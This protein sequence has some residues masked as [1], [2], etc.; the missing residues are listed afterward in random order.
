VEGLEEVDRVM[1]GAVE[2]V[3][4]CPVPVEAAQQATWGVKAGGLGLRTATGMAIPAHVASLVE[5]GP[6][7]EWLA[8]EAAAMGLAVACDVAEVV[9]REV[10]LMLAGVGEEMR[11][12]MSEAVEAAGEKARAA[13]E[14][15]LGSGGDGGGAASRKADEKANTGSGVGGGLQKDLL[16]LLDAMEVRGVMEGLRDSRVA[17]DRVRHRRLADLSGGGPTHAWLAAVNPAHGPVL[18]RRD[19]VTAVRLRLGVPVA[20]YPGLEPCGECGKRLAAEDVGDH[21]L[22]CA[23]GQRVRGHNRIRDHVAALARVADRATQ[24]EVAWA[25]AVEA[26]HHD[27]DRQRPADI[28]TDASPLGG[29]GSAAI[30]VGVTSPHTEDVLHGRSKDAVDDYYRK[31]RVQKGPVAERAGWTYHP[32][33]LSCYGRVHSEATRIV[34]RLALAAAQVYGVDDAGM[35][36]RSW[37]RTCGTLLAVRAAWMV[38]KC[39][40]DVAL[41]AVLG[42]VGDGV[43]AEVLPGAEDTEC[44]VD[45]LV[46]G[47]EVWGGE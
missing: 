41:P 9:R 46:G 34:H 38:G 6:L 11:G 23:R 39:R 26:R 24:V 27:A 10:A 25:T 12:Q 21:A 33:I 43:R 5:S 15:I 22:L 28:L 14:N 20:A 1:T 31:K 19:W 45:R 30:D 4:R 18:Q 29:V 35:I 16:G 13:A 37:W 17:R 42:G 47:G 44:A 36:E 32:F 7:V 3:V 40:P 8:R 2:Q